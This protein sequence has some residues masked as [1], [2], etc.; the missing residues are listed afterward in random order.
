MQT[1]R[2]SG[3]LSHSRG[4]NHLTPP[5][6][7]NTFHHSEKTPTRRKESKIVENEPERLD[8]E[9]RT[10]DSRNDGLRDSRLADSPRERK[11]TDHGR[12][13]RWNGRFVF[14]HVQR[15]TWAVTR[16]TEM[17]GASRLLP[18]MVVRAVHRTPVVV[19]GKDSRSGTHLSS[20]S[21]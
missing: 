19:A 12:V 7:L 5:T 13:S 18:A 8:S 17:E 1:P 10:V 9:G 14:D 2:L 20:L 3:N 21:L 11:S 15:S 6:P 16:G 4:K